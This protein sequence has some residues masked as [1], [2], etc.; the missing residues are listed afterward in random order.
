MNEIEALRE[1]VTKLR[2]RVAVLEAQRAVQHGGQVQIP[3][4]YYP[5]YVPHSG[6]AT[7]PRPVWEVTCST[8]MTGA[9]GG[10]NG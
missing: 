2:E 8:G 9:C 10:S 1:E 7:Y 4:G 5:A 3:L 6:T